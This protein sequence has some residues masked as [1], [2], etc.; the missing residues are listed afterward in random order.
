MMRSFLRT[1]A[2]AGLFAMLT[3]PAMAAVVISSQTTSGD[4]A[5]TTP[6]SNTDLLQTSLL[7]VNPVGGDNL[8]TGPAK[9]NGTTGTAHEQNATNP[10][11]VHNTGTYDFSLDTT[12]VPVGY[13]IDEVNVYTG[14]GDFRAGQDFRAFYSLVGD[15]SFTQYADVNIAHSNGT[16][17][18]SITDDA[19]PIASGVDQLRFI[20]DQSTH[21]YREIDVI[22]AIA[23]P[24]R[25][26][27]GGDGIIGTET[28]TGTQGN[29]VYSPGATGRFVQVK[30]NGTATRRMDIGEVEVFATGVTPTVD[31]AATD[32]FLNPSI[33][34]AYSG[35]T[36]GASVYAKGADSG[37][38]Q[39]HGTTDDP[40]LIDA[41]E[42]DG[43]PLWS[44]NGVGNFVTIDLGNTFDIGTV[45]VHQRNGCCQDRLRDFSV[46]VFE[47][48]GTGNP[49][50]LLASES[51]PGQP[52]NQRFGELSMASLLSADLVASLNPHDFGAGYTYV[53]ELGSADKIE[54]GNPNPSIFTT[55][56]D[57]NN[58]AIEVE[59]LAGATLA[60]GDTFD[61]L[62]ADFIQGTYDSLI[63]PELGGGLSLDD[64]NFL[65]DGTLSVAMIPEP[66]TLVL[67]ALGLLGLLGWGWRR[68]R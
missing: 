12:T 47:D 46:N 6:A 35:S 53:F 26:E 13:R 48:D 34:L 27:V 29:E 21:V 68:K 66:S 58:A 43:W 45:R 42:D 63:L 61:L 25:H 50:A 20:V 17:R 49:G 22:G 28:L 52:P 33:D 57:L 8:L 14:W 10:A 36:D 23:G 4:T 32:Q 59:L 56:L 54:V 38:S 3:A 44:S 60:P 55:Y 7:S 39:P 9:Y 41:R 65:I 1:T 11:T 62:D 16:L 51:Y 40:E 24:V 67:S 37:F 64:S 31:N 5:P 30:N 18:V 19:G 15:A 2:V